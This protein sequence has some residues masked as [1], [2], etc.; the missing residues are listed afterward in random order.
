VRDREEM[1][2]S[3]H[4]AL[5]GA[6]DTEFFLCRSEKYRTLQSIQR[7]GKDLVEVTLALEGDT[8]I[9]TLGLPRSQADVAAAS[10]VILDWLPEQHEPVDE[11]AIKA[12][13]GGRAEDAEKGLRLL[14]RD[15]RVVRTGAGRRG[16]Y[17]YSGSSF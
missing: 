8:S 10:D 9:V 13:V 5:F 11:Q 17:V 16:S 4:T 14:V 2:F 7:Y 3:D 6:V 1:A 12:G 15:G